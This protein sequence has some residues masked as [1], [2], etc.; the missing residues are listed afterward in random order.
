MLPIRDENPS[1]IFPFV[2][3]AIIIACISIFIWTA[4]RGQSNFEAIVEAYGLSPS[5]VLRGDAQY[6]F[7]T[8]IFLHGDLL[9]LL[10]NM[11]RD[12]L[13]PSSGVRM[14]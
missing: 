11:L 7:L 8:S 6:T 5:R 10:G 2:N 1:R 14:K 13:D 4:I 9:H 3:W 12:A